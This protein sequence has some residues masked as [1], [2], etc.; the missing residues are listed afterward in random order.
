VRVGGQGRPTPTLVRLYDRLVI[1]AE[2]ALERRLQPRF[3]QS[4]LCIARV[5]DGAG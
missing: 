3:G 5:P 1:P 4:V 2:R